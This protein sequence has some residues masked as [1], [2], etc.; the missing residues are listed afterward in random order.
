VQINTLESQFISDLSLLQRFLAK[1][2][3]VTERKVLKINNTIFMPDAAFL[4]SVF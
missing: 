3:K 1:Y 2:S 4:V